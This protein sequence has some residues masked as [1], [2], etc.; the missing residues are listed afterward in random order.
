MLPSGGTR[1]EG[2]FGLLGVGAPGAGGE[3]SWGRVVG[4]ATHFVSRGSEEF[5]ALSLGLQQALLVQGDEYQP[6]DQVVVRE[7]SRESDRYSSQH[8]SLWLCRRITHR[9]TV[10]DSNG[11][12]PGWAV[13]SFNTAAENEWSTASLKRRLLASIRGDWSAEDFWRELAAREKKHLTELIR[14]K[15]RP[16]LERRAESA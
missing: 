5:R 9:M 14:L 2:S 16:N 1:G 4:F 12:A 6:G 8:T 11:I 10:V 13:L 7:L 3:E 15:D